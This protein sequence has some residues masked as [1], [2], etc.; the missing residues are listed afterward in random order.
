MLYLCFVSSSHA[1]LINFQWSIVHLELDMTLQ[2]FNLEPDP[3][4]DLLHSVDTS[5]F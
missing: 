5:G 4:Y 3:F 1:Q 2:D